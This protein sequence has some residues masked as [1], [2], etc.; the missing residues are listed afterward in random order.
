MSVRGCAQHAVTGMGVA[1][2]RS[3]CWVA[4]GIWVARVTELHAVLTLATWLGLLPHAAARNSRPTASCHTA[5][6]QGLSPEAMQPCF[7]E[8]R[9]NPCSR[10]ASA[11]GVRL[12]GHGTVSPDKG[13]TGDEQALLPKPS[14]LPPFKA[15][16]PAAT[17]ANPTAYHL[18]PKP[19]FLL[20]LLRV[21]HTCGAVWYRL[22][23]CASLSACSTKAEAQRGSLCPSAFTA[24]PAAKSMYSRPSVSHTLLPKP[25]LSTNGARAYVYR[26]ARAC[27]FEPMKMDIN[28]ADRQEV[29]GKVWERY[30][31]DRM[32]SDSRWTGNHSYSCHAVHPV[33]L[34]LMHEQAMPMFCG[35]QVL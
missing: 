20:L 8:R 30:E 29:R 14:L 12:L 1:C 17:Q 2:H 28:M 11:Q 4:V 6:V 10:Q 16:L 23:V 21:R 24:M 34:C 13:T 5:G 33:C 9:D 26:S 7:L 31:K 19:S 35:E 3:Y 18:P 15:L 25:W 27:M 32:Q 22:L